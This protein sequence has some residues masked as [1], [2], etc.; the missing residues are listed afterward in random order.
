M[1]AK[2]ESVLNSNPSLLPRFAQLSEK[3]RDAFELIGDC[4]LVERIKEPEKK[5][6]SGIIYGLETKNQLG[7]FAQDRPHWVRVLVVGEGWYDE[8]TGESVPLNVQPGDV[9]LVSQ[10]SV[11]YFSTFGDMDGAPADTIGLTR[12]SE[13]QLRFKGEEGFAKAFAALNGGASSGES[14]DG[15]QQELPLP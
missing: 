13:I 5:T 3:A 15:E 9:V 10:V 8:E 1:E 6:A 12:E 7:T 11:K 14:M 4:I 2:K